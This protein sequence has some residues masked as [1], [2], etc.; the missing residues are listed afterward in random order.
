MS[1]KL[2]QFADAIHL[3]FQN[4]NVCWNMLWRPLHNVPF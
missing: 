2:I 1:W 4:Y 3:M